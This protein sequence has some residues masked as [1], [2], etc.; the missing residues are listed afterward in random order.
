MTY[1]LLIASELVPYFIDFIDYEQRVLI[2]F[3]DLMG[4]VVV[5]VH[6]FPS[7]QDVKGSVYLRG[8]LCQLWYCERTFQSLEVYWSCLTQ[9]QLNLPIYY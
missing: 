1:F 4:N 8:H 7:F 5:F 2:V 6:L 9:L 3:E